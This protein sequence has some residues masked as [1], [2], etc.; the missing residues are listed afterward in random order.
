MTGH[1]W[2]VTGYL[3]GQIDLEVWRDR[4]SDVFRGVS[5]VLLCWGCTTA[6][7][8][9]HL[10]VALVAADVHALQHLCCERGTAVPWVRLM[11]A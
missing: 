11:C 4:S 7:Q 9:D 1:G 5:V 3:R 10:L 8:G 6:S 2:H